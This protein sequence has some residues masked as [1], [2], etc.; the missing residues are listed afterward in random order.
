MWAVK[1]E[2]CARLSSE[3]RRYTVESRS[4][5]SEVNTAISCPMKFYLPVYTLLRR[6]KPI[7]IQLRR[8]CATRVVGPLNRPEMNQTGPKKKKKVRQTDI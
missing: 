2:Q 3:K 7:N 1:W 6:S 4:S 8:Y 5:I